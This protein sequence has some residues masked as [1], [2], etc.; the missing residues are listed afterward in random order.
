M[1]DDSDEKECPICE[2]PIQEHQ[3]TEYWGGVKEVHEECNPDRQ[4]GH[5]VVP[6][7][8]DHVNDGPDRLT[9]GG[10][11]ISEEERQRLQMEVVGCKPSDHQ[12]PVNARI[13]VGESVRV[14]EY[15][16][17]CNTDLES[18]EYS[19]GVEV[20]EVQLTNGKTE[21]LTPTGTGGSE[22]E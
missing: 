15:C 6:N 12:G 1:T 4:A 21:T 2:N 7:G 10:I 11:N 3:D 14:T 5:S 16:K 8:G 22:D 19:P 18:W 13:D 17:A 9:D 20:V